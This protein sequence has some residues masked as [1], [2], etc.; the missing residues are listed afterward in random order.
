[1]TADP[2]IGLAEAVLV[3]TESEVSGPTTN[4]AVV[5][6]VGVREFHLAA[7]P[8]QWLELGLQPLNRLG[9]DLELRLIVA[10][11]DGVAEERAFFRPSH[12]ALGPVELQS[13]QE[14]QASHPRQLR[15]G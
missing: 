7:L 9:C 5:P 8:K 2:T 15:H 3:P 4:D 11:G 14:V 12:R 10:P 1:M 13:V 6:P